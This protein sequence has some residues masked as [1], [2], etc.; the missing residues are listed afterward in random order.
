MNLGRNIMINKSTYRRSRKYQKIQYFTLIMIL[1]IGLIIPLIF[2][3]SLP[4]S[5]YLN[6]EKVVNDDIKNINMNSYHPDMWENFEDQYLNDTKWDNYWKFSQVSFDSN[7][8]YEGDYS[9]KIENDDSWYHLFWNTSSPNI[10]IN[11]YPIF[12]FAL[13]APRDTRTSL[14]VFLDGHWY[15]AATT[16]NGNKTYHSAGYNIPYL[17]NYLTIID[18]NDWH[19]YEYDLSQTG[20][21]NISCFGFF[22]DNWSSNKNEP[23]KSYWVDNIELSDT[24]ISTQPLTNDWYD[25][26]YDYR[27]DINI[28]EPNIRQRVKEPVNIYL[29]FPNGHTYNNSI[30]TT[31]Y[32]NGKFRLVSSQVWNISYYGGTSYIQSCTLTILADLLKGQTRRYYIYYAAEEVKS[33]EYSDLKLME[34][35]QNNLDI[36][37]PVYNISFNATSGYIDSGYFRYYSD[38]QNILS[39]SYCGIITDFADDWQGERSYSANINVIEKGTTFINISVSK[40]VFNGH[41]LQKVFLFYPTYIKIKVKVETGSI[42]PNRIVFS[43]INIDNGVLNAYYLDQYGNDLLVDASGGSDGIISDWPSSNPG[44]WL[45]EYSNTSIPWGYS[46]VLLG[47]SASDT[48]YYDGGLENGHTGFSIA[49]AASSTYW[50][51]IAFVPHGYLIENDSFGQIDSKVLMNPAFYSR[52]AERLR[53]SRVNNIGEPININEY[54]RSY[55]TSEIGI[56]SSSTSFST[57]E[58]PSHWDSGYIITEINDLTENAS[59]LPNDFLE[60]GSTGENFHESIGGESSGSGSYKP[61]NWDY[62]WL[63]IDGPS[64]YSNGQN[65]LGFKDYNGDGKNDLRASIRGDNNDAYADYP[66]YELDTHSRWKTTV[67][68]SAGE[69][70]GAQLTFNYSA[71]GWQYAHAQI[72]VSID[73]KPIFTRSFATFPGTYPIID[74]GNWYYTKIDIPVSYLPSLPGSFQFSLGVETT[75]DSST[76]GNGGDASWT[77]VTFSDIHLFVQKEVKPTAIGLK[78]FTENDDSG[79]HVLEDDPNGNFGISKTFIVPFNNWMGSDYENYD[80]RTFYYTNVAPFRLT[81]KKPSVSFNVKQTFYGHSDKKS[82][83][84]YG[85]TEPGVRFQTNNGGNTVWNFNLFASQPQIQAPQSDIKDFTMSFNYPLDWNI[86]ELYNP[87]SPPVDKL[88]ETNMVLRQRGQGNYTSG[89]AWWYRDIMHPYYVTQPGDY[90]YYDIKYPST[91]ETRI[92]AI[93]LEFATLG[94][95]RDSG[96]TDQNGINAHPAVDLSAYADDVWYHRKIKIPDARIGGNITTVEMALEHDTLTTEVYY[97]HIYIGDENGNVRLPI[98]WSGSYNY[99][100]ESVGPGNNYYINIVYDTVYD[101]NSTSPSYKTMDIPKDIANIFGYWSVVAESP[102]YIS[103]AE[104]RDGNNLEIKNAF[105]VGDKMRINASIIA[106]PFGVYDGITRLEIYNPNDQIWHAEDVN[107]P[108]GGQ[109]VFSDINLAASNTSVGEYQIYIK[110]NDSTETKGVSEAGLKI[111]SFN[112]THSTSINR[113]TPASQLLTE[114]QGET[115]IFKVQYVDSDTSS[116]IIDANVSFTANGWDFGSDYHGQMVQIQNGIYVGELNTT[117]RLGHYN[118]DIHCEKDYYDNINQNDYYSVLILKDTELSYDAV[119]SISFG[120]NASITI[121]YLNS[122]ELGVI[123]AELDLNVSYDTPSYNPESNSYTVSIRTDSLMEGS[124][125]IELN[126]SKIYHENL[127]IDI[128]ITI[129]PIQTALS[130]D[131]PSP[132]PFGFNVS[133]IATY[134]IDDPYSSNNGQGITSIDDLTIN[135]TES[136]SYSWA[137]ISNGQY[138]INI[139]TFDWDIGLYELNL[140]FYKDHYINKSIFV[141]IEIREHYTEVTYL[142]QEPVPWGLNITTRITFKDLDL[143]LQPIT[144][145]ITTITANGTQIPYINLGSG[146]YNI[147]LNTMSLGVG[148]YSFNIIVYADNYDNNTNNYVSIVIREHKTSFIYDSPAP[149]PFLDNITIQFYY[150]DEDNEESGIINDSNLLLTCEVISPHTLSPEYWISDEPEPGKYIIYISTSNFPEVNIYHIEMNLT[151]IKDSEYQNQSKEIEVNVGSDVGNNIGRLTDITYDTPDSSPLGDNATID[152]YYIDIDDSNMP[153]ISNISSNLQITI[154]IKSHSVSPIYWIEDLNAESLGKYR[155]LIDTDSLLGNDTYILQVKVN[156]SNNSPFYQNQSKDITF[157]VR[158]N[159]T[160]L[161]YSPPGT[162][163]WSD[164]TNASISITYWDIDHNTGIRNADIDFTLVSPSGYTFIY[165]TNW[166]YTYMGSGKYSIEIAMENLTEQVYTFDITANKSYYIPRTLQNVNL[167]IRPRYTYVS[168]PQYPSANIPLG[169]Y[170]LSVYYIDK[171]LSEYILNDSEIQFNFLTYDLNNTWRDQ[172]NGNSSI[173]NASLIFNAIEKCWIITINTTN[174]DLDKTYNITI[175][176]T[177][178]HFEGQIVNISLSLEKRSTLMGI[179][180]PESTVWG[181]NMTFTIIYTDLGGNY[182]PNVKINMN[183][184]KLS[185]EYYTVI[186][187][188]DGNYTVKLNTTAHLAQQYNLEINASATNFMLRTRIILLS[189]RSIDTFIDYTPPPVTAW[190]KLLTFSLEYSDLIHDEA[191]NGTEIQISTNVTLGFWNWEYDQSKIGSYIININTQFRNYSMGNNYSVNFNVNWSGVPYYQNQTFNV[192]I[193]T[194]QR[195]TE[196]IYQPPGTVYYGANSTFN[197]Q[198]NDLDNSSIGI[199]NATNPWGS[200]IKIKIFHENGTLFAPLND[201]GWINEIGS[202]DYQI[203]LNTSQLSKTGTYNFIIEVNWDFIAPYYSNNTVNISII[204]RPINTEIQIIPPLATGYGLNS[205]IDITYWDVDNELGILDINNQ[206]NITVWDS[207][208]DLWNTSGFAWIRKLGSGNWQIKINTS[209]LEGLGE[210]NFTI[211]VNW[212][213]KPFYE[214]TSTEIKI[215]IRQRITEMPYDPPL[216]TPYSDKVNFTVYFND[217]DAQEGIDNS[218]GN[219]YFFIEDIVLYKIYNMHFEQRG[220]YQIEINT[221]DPSLGIGYHFINLNVSCYGKP[222]YTNRSISV[223]LNVREINTELNAIYYLNSISY[224]DNLTITLSFNDSDHDYIGIPISSENIT[225]GWLLGYDFINL[226]QGAFNIEINTSV[227][228]KQWSTWIYAEKQNYESANITILFTVRKISTDYFTNASFVNNWKWNQNLTIEIGYLDID[229]S[230]NV[231]GIS[232]SNIEITS[233]EPWNEGKN[234]S[235]IFDNTTNRFYLTLNTSYISEETTYSIQVNLHQNH[236][237]NQ[238]FSI[239]LTFRYPSSS[240]FVLDALPSTTLAW[241]DNLTIKLTLNDTETSDP[242]N[243]SIWLTPISLFPSNNYTIYQP[244]LG[245]YIIELNTTWEGRPEDTYTILIRGS[246]P[247]YHNTSSAIVITIRKIDTS[248]NI[249]STPPYIN[250]QRNGSILLQFNDSELGHINIGL[251]NSI[252]E[253]YWKDQFGDLYDWDSTTINGSYAIYENTSSGLYT[254][255]INTNTNLGIGEW[256]IY[257]NASLDPDVWG[258]VAYH[259]QMGEATFTLRITEI[260]TTLTP[261]TIP[262]SDIPWGQIFNITVQYNNTF[263]NIGIENASIH[264]QNWGSLSQNWNYYYIDNGKYKISINSSIINNTKLHQ[265]LPINLDIN[266]TNYVSKTMTIYVTIRE[267]ETRADFT[268]P[269][270]IP[271]NNTILINFTYSDIDNS[272]PILNSTGRVRIKCNI[273]DWPDMDNYDIYNFGAGVFGIEIDTSYLPYPNYTYPIN[274]NITHSGKPYYINQSFTINL[275]VRKVSTVLVINP[276][277]AQPFGFDVNITIEYNVSDPISIYDGNGIEDAMINISNNYSA[278]SVRSTAPGKYIITIDRND[279]PNVGEYSLWISI[280]KTGHVN[281]NK[282]FNFNVR[283]RITNLIH[284]PFQSLPYANIANI[285]FQYLDIDNNSQIITNKSGNVRFFIYNESSLLSDEYAWVEYKNYRYY[286]YID[287]TKLSGLGSYNYTIQSNWTNNLKYL[288]A[289]D[290]ITLKLKSRNTEFINDPLDIIYYGQ[291]LTMTIYY[292]DLDNN[293]QGITNSSWGG[294]KLSISALID[295]NISQTSYN[296]KEIGN[297]EYLLTFNSSLILQNIIGYHQIEINISWVGKPFYK[298]KT[299]TDTFTIRKIYT[300]FKVIIGDVATLDYTGWQW[301]RNASIWVYYNN[302]DLNTLIEDSHLTLSGE[303]PYENNNTEITSFANG[304]FYI[305]LNGT[306]PEHDVKYYFDLTLYKD[307]RYINQTT[308]ISITFLKNFSNIFFRSVNYSISWGDNASIIFSYN[309]TESAGQPGI[310]NA[311]INISVDQNA[312]NESFTFYELGGGIYKIEMNSTWAPNDLVLVKFNIY[313]FRIEYLPVNTSKVIQIRPISTELRIVEY[314]YTV[315]K[316]ASP[317]SDHFNITV[318]L[319]DIDHNNQLI[320]NNSQTKYENVSFFIQ[321]DE[322]ISDNKWEYGNFTAY[323]NETDPFLKA[324]NYKLRFYWNQESPELLSY[325]LNIYV[326][327]SHLSLSYL[328]ITFNLKI[329]YHDTNMTLDWNYANQVSDQD[330]PYFDKFDP[331]AV[332]YYGDIINITF[333]W[334]DLNASNTGI[335]PGYHYISCNWSTGHYLPVALYYEY[336]YNTSYYGLYQ[337]QLDTNLL[338]KD[339]VKEWAVNISIHKAEFEIIYRKSF[340][341]LKFN[342]TSIPTNLTLNEPIPVTPWSDS[343]VINTSYT[344][345]YRNIGVLNPDSIEVIPWTS[346]TYF[347]EYYG[348][349]NYVFSLLTKDIVDVGTHEINILIEKLNYDPINVTFYAEVR[350]ISTA[351]DPNSISY[352]NMTYRE[353]QEIRFSYIDLDHYNNPIKSYTTIGTNWSGEVTI[354]PY[355][356]IARIIIN[357]SIDVGTYNVL[358]WANSTHYDKATYTISITIDP[359]PT[360]IDL[361]SPPPVEFY[362]GKTISLSIQLNNSVSETMD[363]ATIWIEI[364]SPNSELVINQT[365]I[366]LEDGIYTIDINTLPCWSNDVYTIKIVAKP[367]NT[368]YA[369]S[370]V[371]YPEIMLVKSMFTHPLAIILY[372]IAGVISGI[373]V[374]RQIRWYLLPEVLK[375]IITNKKRIKK[376]KTELKVPVVRNRQEMFQDE[377]KREWAILGIGLKPLKVMSPEVISFASEMSAALRS[378]ITATEAEKIIS[379]LRS[380]DSQIESENYLQSLNIPPGA[381]KRLLEIIGIIEKEKVEILEFA[382]ALSEIKGTALDYSQAEEIMKVLLSSP[383][384]ADNYLKAMIIPE[385]DRKRLL[386]MIGIQAKDKKS[387]TSKKTKK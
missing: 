186:D 154:E 307:E 356:G 210:Y 152:I 286:I 11:S 15:A 292:K 104:I 352:S 127:S 147:T 272:V 284:T 145:P 53:P 310:P 345:L 117:G 37:T 365:F 328:Q 371:I 242:I 215:R 261:I 102:N 367:K 129:R 149:T 309:D 362:Q 168:S 265:A 36:I 233:P 263:K 171:E 278:Y 91:S 14:I 70:I 347:V 20:Y 23:I 90:L 7:D 79:V 323:G 305:E 176:I 184:S 298:N 8:P 59:S 138:S 54:G 385:E 80:F 134:T 380:L 212:T 111:L 350:N 81:P 289:S 105:R 77:N 132:E 377:F 384:D 26:D 167:T 118:I 251:N 235:L 317:D 375:K 313:A 351:I 106:D 373:V 340:R 27:F 179:I 16:V 173:A 238:S 269:D 155:I 260:D 268:P 41:Q 153:G 338:G 354:L 300:N 139:S 51:E 52:G 322:T 128:P 326:N 180:N 195:N 96:A 75:I 207:Y 267:I 94:N 256:N 266:K 275:M 120:E 44:E 337:I 48:E 325:Q 252:I 381:T 333:F 332:Y 119:P 182:I 187:E 282:S 188:G 177:K 216:T 334:Y 97:R 161:S 28:S 112:I 9:L 302:S 368:N 201:K 130:Y 69:I 320:I 115:A 290:T 279:L 369:T 12:R 211:L 170:N 363:N 24:K 306:V 146:N 243:G 280:N 349:T 2:L 67:S 163:A 202:G 99:P 47:G 39:N 55:K 273:T 140:T 353:K 35:D 200:Y 359:M 221:S 254:I 276:L 208:N 324:G 172:L 3:S 43:R 175:N 247:N 374:Y 95:L 229:H 13:K 330:I 341:L 259:Y 222:Y 271:I 311:Q 303:G 5:N 72:N 133:F 383:T 314:N 124:Y 346:G 32:L 33:K 136:I 157:I 370:E 71:R 343:I 156:W 223:G 190:G 199:T 379:Y 244:S 40:T 227:Q 321:W 257:V 137:H 114:Y 56:S 230:S 143:N 21:S 83:Q 232:L 4:N 219:I 162:V 6:S 291:N 237:I 312:A 101:S 241:G 358:L 86:I 296:I 361:I 103:D 88:S 31:Y 203:I 220:K 287:T 60:S 169:L 231:S 295:N 25:L 22:S 204:I 214:N 360:Q 49:A 329:H 183:W 10:D 19:L 250:F 85:S 125:T 316:D 45:S 34:I 315:W 57:L 339:M 178:N 122:S 228:E 148:R 378:R 58:I 239:N 206:A 308:T 274:I 93:D 42:S 61:I 217:L 160:Y 355:S 66:I 87:Q 74:P 218:T 224:N 151:W 366:H 46:S 255:V 135:E 30:I 142:S 144:D 198:Y 262:S 234:S 29:T 226:G 196:I 246:A 248:L 288:N 213:G 342:I 387:K 264:I 191:I 319:L 150:L 108:A 82:T 277:T 253:L 110:Y 205:T 281:L 240:I 62:E 1:F 285:S 382:K 158:Y 89:N 348:G 209:K 116:G 38:S 225:C 386:E 327:G 331:N 181:E 336:D 376:G 76:G 174:F 197:I 126:A 297:G 283:S 189:I 304:S 294:N 107:V 166:T 270:I 109:V 17:P 123:D 335:R 299:L 92:G 164:T 194:R 357:A 113:I 318:E 141:S 344:D 159:N 98:Y 165:N 78:M 131:A 121:Y 84:T 245:F 193:F 249:I 236:Y 372:I 64:S 258:Q 364:Y 185:T 68:L 65:I 301:G 73:G 100:E 293:S 18:D 192:L 63:D 50:N